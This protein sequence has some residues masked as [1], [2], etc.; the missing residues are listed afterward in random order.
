[1]IK[2]DPNPNVLIS[3]GT[4]SAVGFEQSR[5]LIF[6]IPQ[7]TDYSAATH[8]IWELAHTTSMPVLLLSLCKDAAEQPGLRREMITMASL[9]QAGKINAEAQVDSGS[10][11]LDVVKKNF[12]AEDRIVC[13]AEQRAGL[14]RKPLSQILESNFNGTVYILSGM[15][16]QTSRSNRLLPFLAW[17]GSLGIVIG[18]GILQAKIVQLPQN[19]IQNALLI[20]SI[21]PEFWLI[22]VWNSL[23]G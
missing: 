5:R 17:I 10:N 11:W 3:P 6:L 20:L 15:T 18:F 1:M 8:R 21:F 4:P 12:Q 7:G 14:L 16:P 22:W 9:L 2:L 23:F 13:F 19:S